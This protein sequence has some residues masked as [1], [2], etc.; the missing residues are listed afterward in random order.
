MR[1]G[2]LNDC[3]MNEDRMDER[4]TR[5]DRMSEDGRVRIG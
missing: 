3:L 1:F 2:G 5:E 4:R